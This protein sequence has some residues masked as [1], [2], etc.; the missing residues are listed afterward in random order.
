M[1][2]GAGSPTM[3]GA[4]PTRRRGTTAIAV[5]VADLRAAVGRRAGDPAATRLVERLLEGGEE[6]AALGTCTRSPYA[7]H[8]TCA[9]CTR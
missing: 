5:H 4:P 7:G 8:R 2:S 6:L 1:W 9:S 3:P